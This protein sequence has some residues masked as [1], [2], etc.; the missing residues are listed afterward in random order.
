MT[1]RAAR[2]C[3]TRR[4]PAISGSRAAATVI[5]MDTGRAPPLS[6]SQEAHAGCLA[7][8]LS[9]KQHRHRRQL[10]RAEHEP[11]KLAAGRARDRRAFDRDAE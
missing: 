10:R 9:W 7:F 4:I 8:E 6:V 5:L 1:M 3:R 11:R 2:R